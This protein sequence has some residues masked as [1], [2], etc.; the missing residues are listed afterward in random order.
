MIS[1]D[2]TVS[3]LQILLCVVMCYHILDLALSITLQPNI[4]QG[5]WYVFRLISYLLSS[6]FPFMPVQYGNKLRFFIHHK[7]HNFFVTWLNLMMPFH[8]IS[9]VHFLKTLIWRSCISVP[10]LFKYHWRWSTLLTFTL[11]PSCLS[12][13]NPQSLHI[14]TWLHRIFDIVLFCSSALTLFELN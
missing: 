1:S 10:C 6:R 2:S 8:L 11:S 9:R 5:I 14:H 13:E 7:E 3:V 4:F 12:T